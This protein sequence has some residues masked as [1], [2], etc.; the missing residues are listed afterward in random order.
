LKHFDHAD[1][2]RTD[3]WECADGCGTKFVTGFEHRQ[4]VLRLALMEG[5]IGNLRKDLERVTMERDAEYVRKDVAHEGT[6]KAVAAER[7]ACARIAEQ[8]KSWLG[9]VNPIIVADVCNRVASAIRARGQPAKPYY[10][11]SM[12]FL[13]DY[14]GEV[15]KSWVETP[16]IPERLNFYLGSPARDRLHAPTESD[17]RNVGMIIYEALQHE[18]I[19]GTKPVIEVAVKFNAGQR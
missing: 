3:Y 19:T 8:G 18:K 11:P 9:W 2:T 14:M 5:E 16:A 1:G 12:P 15:D 6:R 4:A 17:L 10:K 13:P 7:E